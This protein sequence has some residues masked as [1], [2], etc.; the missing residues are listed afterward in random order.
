MLEDLVAALEQ[1][2][3]EF[4]L[5]DLPLLGG[6]LKLPPRDVGRDGSE[7][8]RHENSGQSLHQLEAE[9]SRLKPAGRRSGWHQGSG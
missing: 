1:I 6:D 2:K 8:E 9:A 3:I 4:G 7:D 5:S